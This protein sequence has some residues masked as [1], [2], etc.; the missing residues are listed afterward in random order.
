MSHA[1]AITVIINF[2]KPSL[3]RGPR[4]HAF[5]HS[6]GFPCAE[7]YSHYPRNLC[8]EMLRDAIPALRLP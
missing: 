3:S 1:A 7:V 4:V 8:I 2:M 5:L 6:R